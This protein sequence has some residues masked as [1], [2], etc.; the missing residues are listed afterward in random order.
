M[1]PH[2]DAYAFGSGIITDALHVQ[3]GEGFGRIGM[4][5]GGIAFAVVYI[6]GDAAIADDSMISQLV[7]GAEVDIILI[8]LEI[9]SR[10]KGGIRD[11]VSVPPMK[12]RLSGVEPGEIFD[13]AAVVEIGEEVGFEKGAGPGADKQH[14]QGV[15]WGRS[16][17]TLMPWPPG[18]GESSLLSSPLCFTRYIP[19]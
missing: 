1:Y 15:R 19:A 2:A 18:S 16:A 12:I 14:R 13:G 9:Y 17:L 3:T 7:T 6:P 11:D 10:L 8:G 5:T 4:R